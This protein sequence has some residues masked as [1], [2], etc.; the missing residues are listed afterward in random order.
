M[1][2]VHARLVAS[3]AVPYARQL[4]NGWGKAYRAG[5]TMVVGIVVGDDLVAHRLDALLAGEVRPATRFPV[6][7][8][9]FPHG[10]MV[11][12]DL[13]GAVF[14]MSGGSSGVCRVD[15]AGAL[16]WH[17]RYS[18]CEGDA[19]VSS[20]GRWVWTVVADGADGAVDG[21]VSVVVLDAANGQELGRIAVPDATLRQDQLIAHPGGQQ[22]AVVGAR[23]GEEGPYW[24]TAYWVRPQPGVG[25]QL[26]QYPSGS[27][28]ITGFDPCGT[29]VAMTDVYAKYVRLRRF[30]SGAPLLTV[31][32]GAATEFAAYTGFL[33]STTMLASSGTG[34][35][36]AEHWLLDTSH[37]GSG[38]AEDNLGG[39]R[40]HPVRY[41]PVGPQH[42]LPHLWAL[43]DGTWLTADPGTLYRWTIAAS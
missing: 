14:P 8:D 4:V 35:N 29:V 12:P 10:A 1:I 15:S 27:E 7:A 39:P 25:L 22:V 17:W 26:R 11:A 34:Q 6:P 30:D 3:V 13:S 2:Q 19:L 21:L 20:D 28:A 32:A 36:D 31:Q 43:G 23:E 41:P 33:D 5:G 9:S 16:R 24:S 40:T 18:Y 42:P 37:D 38:P